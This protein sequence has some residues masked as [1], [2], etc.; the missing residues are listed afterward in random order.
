MDFNLNETQT[1][2]Q[3]GA[4][5]FFQDRLDSSKVRDIEDSEDGFAAEHWTQ[6]TELGWTGLALPEDVGGAGCGNVDLCVLAEE[7][8]RAAAS[9]PLVET[10]GFSATVLQ[11]VEQTPVTKALLGE[12]AT[13]DTVITPALIEPDGRDERSRPKCKL[14]EAGDDGKVTG[15]KVMI[16]FGSAAKVFLTSLISSEGELILAAIDST[17]PGISLERHKVLGG[18]PMFRATFKDVDVAAA[19]ILA[20]GDAAEKVLNAGLDAATMLSVAEAVGNLEGMIDICADYTSTRE[21]FG[22]KIGSYQAVSHPVANMRIDTDACRLLIAEAAW[23]LDQGQDAA[24]EIA[25]TKV[26]ANEAAVTMVHAAHAVHGAI[27]YTMEYD[28]QLFTRRVRAFCLSYGDTDGQTERAAAT[29]LA[30]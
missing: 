9:L 15:A 5:R 26:F 2:I 21:Q 29:L 30:G 18:S 23:I 19:N 12:I 24:L 1:M 17:A 20:R 6:L 25:E 7:V 28:L 27:G 22:K 8:G 11:A 13:S 4:R 14:V 10:V 3:D 16:P